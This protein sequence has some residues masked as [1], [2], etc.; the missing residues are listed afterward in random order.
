MKCPRCRAINHL[1]A[2]CPEPESLRASCPGVNDG[3][4]S[5]HSVVG[6]QTT[7]S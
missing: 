7:P 1:R 3:Q 6:R 5:H 4:Q 2:A